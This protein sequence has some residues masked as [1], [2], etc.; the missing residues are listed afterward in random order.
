MKKTLRQNLKGLG[1]QEFEI[2]ERMT[3]RSKDLYNEMLYEVRQ[4]FF[5]NGEYLNYYNAYK[6]LKPKSENYEVLPSQM[7]QQTMRNV[8]HAFKS[9]FKLVEKKSEG[10]FDGEV[11]PPNYLDKDGH[12][13]LIFPNQSFQ[14][15]DDHIRIGIPKSFREE[16][17][18][19]KTE[20]RV[21][22]TYE[23]LKRK[24]VKIKQ[25]HIIPKGDAQYFEYRIV[26]EEEKEPIETEE[27]TWLS[28]DLGVD[29]LATCVDHSGRSFILDGRNLK[30][31]N[32]WMNKEIARLQSIKDKQDIDENTERINKLFKDRN[33]Y[34]HDYLNKAV[35]TIVEYCKDNKIKKVVVGDG[36]GW[37]QEVNNGD[38][39]NQNFVQI[40]F[41][42]FKQKLKHKVEHY[43]IEFE[44]VDE[45]HTSKCSFFDSESVE[46]HEEYVGERVE[47]GLFKT[48]DGQ[49]INADINGALNIARKGKLETSEVESS[50]VVDTPKR[51]RK[52]FG[53]RCDQDNGQIQPSLEASS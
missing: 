32:R 48:N 49:L 34:I 23:K 9:F 10:K 41:D 31:F 39:I 1:K 53:L 21:D 18:F 33:N 44:L 7:A 51:I 16:Y 17:G 22:F 15:K 20:I 43:G 12:Y 26:Y 24:E 11:S 47:R 38:K 36:K 2:L 28:I 37:K 30:S 50:G 52:P 19:D 4:Y 27:G 13:S 42:K 8:D 14:V 45:S 25:L 29:N 5:N 35:N 40:P 46:H 6:R 3:H